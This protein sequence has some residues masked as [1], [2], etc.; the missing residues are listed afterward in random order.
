MAVLDP[1][2]ATARYREDL[3]EELPP[4]RRTV[5]RAEVLEFLASL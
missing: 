3:L 2:L 5:N 1:R 4:L